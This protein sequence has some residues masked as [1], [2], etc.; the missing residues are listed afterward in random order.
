MIA[1]LRI[2]LRIKNQRFTQTKNHVVKK[3]FSIKIKFARILINELQFKI[4]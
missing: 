4:R 2:V 1:R 3:K